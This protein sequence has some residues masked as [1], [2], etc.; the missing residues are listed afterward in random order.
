MNRSQGKNY[1][2]K[3]L[4]K[5]NQ[6]HVAGQTSLQPLDVLGQPSHQ[7]EFTGHKNS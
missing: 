5:G 3:Y 6:F 4:K 2:Q 1:N 7:Q